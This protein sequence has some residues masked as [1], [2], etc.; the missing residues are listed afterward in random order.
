VKTF[1][2]KKQKQVKKVESIII[3]NTKQCY[4]EFYEHKQEL[5]DYEYDNQAIE[6][7]LQLRHVLGNT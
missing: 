6:K 3:G 5:I 4:G 1:G 2:E 7:S